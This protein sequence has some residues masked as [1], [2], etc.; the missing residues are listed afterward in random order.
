MRQIIYS[1]I[2]LAF[3]SGSQWTGAQIVGNMNAVN[4]TIDTQAT[5]SKT[6]E[7]SLIISP[8]PTTNHFSFSNNEK[9]GKVEV[10]NIIGAKVKSF[11]TR[12]STTFNVIDLPSGIY[13]VRAYDKSNST[14]IATLRL[15]KR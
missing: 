7:A 1:I 5:T 12:E 6:D 8:N 3:I 2:F 11:D 15:K 13:L 9:I 10:Y 4:S 14:V